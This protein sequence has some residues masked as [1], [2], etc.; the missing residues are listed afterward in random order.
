MVRQLIQTE[1][2]QQAQVVEEF[3]SLA[4]QS[5][6]ELSAYLREKLGTNWHFCGTCKMGVDPLAVV[7]PQLN[8]YGVQGLRV[9][10]ASVMPEIVGGNTNAPT[11]MIA[12]KAA[13]FI[14]ATE[15]H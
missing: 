2:Y 15:L 14:K 4:V 3:P 5:D 13:D 1:P 8:V 10:D 12:E 11:M 6:L 7:S 9:A